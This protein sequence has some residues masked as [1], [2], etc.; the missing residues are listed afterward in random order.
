MAK[1]RD[2]R[3]SDDSGGRQTR[4]FADPSGPRDR[5]NPSTTLQP[6]S[7]QCK[8]AVVFF[9]F[10]VA[11]AAI[12]VFLYRINYSQTMDRTL[13]HVHRRGLVK[14]DLNYL[15]ILTV[16]TIISLLS[17]PPLPFRLLSFSTVW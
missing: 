12:S 1:R 3:A 7:K 9:V 10:F 2:R 8:L 11:S 17:L 13:P 4:A 14:A 16:C 5:T 15:E 6:Q